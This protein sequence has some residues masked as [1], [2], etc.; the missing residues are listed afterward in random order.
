MENVH[1]YLIENA[2]YHALL[3]LSAPSH[4]EHLEADFVWILH[5]LQ[6]PVIYKLV[7]FVGA[8]LLGN[9]VLGLF[10]HPSLL[11]SEDTPDV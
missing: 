7:L 10:Q 1:L 4:A 8:S 3:A 9:S 6:I 2:Y 5:Q 11:Q